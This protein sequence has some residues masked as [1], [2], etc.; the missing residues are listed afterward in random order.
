MVLWMC[1]AD[2]K[3][4][5]ASNGMYKVAKHQSPFCLLGACKRILGKGMLNIAEI[6]T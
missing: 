5:L 3:E 4:I 1:R 2:L 6:V